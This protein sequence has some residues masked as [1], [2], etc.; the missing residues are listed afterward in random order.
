MKKQ[1]KPFIL[2]ALTCTFL[3][4]ASIST[5]AASKVSIND[6]NFAQAVK[7]YAENADTNK[8]GYLSKK[9][10]SKITKVRFFSQYNIDS[11][12]GIEY[13]TDIENF[14]YRADYATEDYDD[15]NI[16]ET[17]TAPEINLSGFKKLTQVTIDSRNPYLKTV[18][19]QDCTNLKNVTIE[20]RR[21]DCIDTLNL[22]GCTN[23]RSLTLNWTNV[24][25]LNLSGLKKLKE[26]TVTD[27]RESLQ[28]LNLKNCSSLKTVSVSGDRLSKLKLKGAKKLE[29]LDVSGRSLESLDLK[30][31]T[32]LKELRLGWGTKTPSLDL[33]KNRSL[34]TLECYRTELVSL[35]LSSNPNLTKVDCHNNP[36][37]SE[38]NVKGCEKL[39]SLRIDNTKLTKLNVKKTTN[40][41]TLRC[42][43]TNITKLNLKNNKKLKKLSC[44]DTNI[45]E[46]NLANTSI[47]KQSALKCDPDVRVTYATK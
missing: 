29:K 24:N 11:F 2:T 12:K 10:A 47:R 3:L 4:G 17:S 35:D 36:N 30:T 38:L 34:T 39:K 21:E 9:E 32:Q 37:L 27:D 31:N 45:R 15:V 5:E 18:N 19:L 13:F 20:G 44:S 46:L 41:R 33:S 40:L 26:V 42:D 28:T 43:N 16:Y 6:T 7:E 1:L 8:D 25:K 23:L 14:Y 22:K